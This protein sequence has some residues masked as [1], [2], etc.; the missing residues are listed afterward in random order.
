MTSRIIPDDEVFC[1]AT[2]AAE[3]IREAWQL[4]YDD[5]QDYHDA[6]WMN[7]VRLWAQFEAACRSQLFETSYTL[8]TSRI[9]PDDEVLAEAT[10]AGE[11]ITE[12]W[13]STNAYEEDHNEEW[14]N[15][16]RLWLQ[17][18]AVCRSQLFEAIAILINPDWQAITQAT[19]MSETQARQASRIGAITLPILDKTT[20]PTTR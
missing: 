3:A 11:A 10:V 19:G 2:V 8:M 17:L 7:E 14:V 6:E 13:R 18:A 12:T 15:H 5:N 9:I 4:N 1:Q 20:R 16:A